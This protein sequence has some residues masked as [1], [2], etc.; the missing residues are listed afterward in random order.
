MMAM[1]MMTTGMTMTAAGSELEGDRSHA[2][3][4]QS[5]H[6]KVKPVILKDEQDHDDYND[7]DDDYNQS[8]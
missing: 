3:N 8:C 4:R 6:S 7:C 2:S 1:T 5:W